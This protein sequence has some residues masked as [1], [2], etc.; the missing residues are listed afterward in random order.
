MKRQLS[1]SFCLL[2]HLAG[3]GT[4]LGA[5]DHRMCLETKQRLC[6]VTEVNKV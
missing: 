1:S 3:L 6:A 2:V 5:D 4:E